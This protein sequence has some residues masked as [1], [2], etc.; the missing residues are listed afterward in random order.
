LQSV[1][2]VEPEWE[3]D[4]TMAYSALQGTPGEDL[5]LSSVFA[6]WRKPK[7]PR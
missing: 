7:G 3:G 2:E 5:L 6:I 4:L 1:I